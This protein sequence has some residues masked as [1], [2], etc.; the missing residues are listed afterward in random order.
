MINVLR[1]NTTPSLNFSMKE[2]HEHGWILEKKR[3]KAISHRCMG[4]TQMNMDGFGEEA[5]QDYLPRMHGTRIA[6]ADRLKSKTAIARELFE[7]IHLLIFAI[8]LIPCICG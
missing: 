4:C 7:K 1:D 2:W 6:R 3:G 8:P 5:R